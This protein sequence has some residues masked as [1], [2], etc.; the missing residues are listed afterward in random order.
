MYGPMTI[1]N[2]TNI[3]V[4]LYLFKLADPLFYLSTSDKF[5]TVV[6]TGLLPGQYQYHFADEKNLP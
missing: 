6:R 5:L 1:S 4:S 3:V 2:D